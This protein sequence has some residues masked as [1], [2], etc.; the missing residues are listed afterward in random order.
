MAFMTFHSVGVMSSS[1]TITPSQVSAVQLQLLLGMA[2]RCEPITGD[3]WIPN[4]DESWEIHGDML[5]TSVA[6]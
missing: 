5:A 1:Q 2:F 6:T 3:P 4:G